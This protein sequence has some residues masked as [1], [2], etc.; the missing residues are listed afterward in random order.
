MDSNQIQQLINA[1]KAN[2]LETHKMRRSFVALRVELK[3]H[4]DVQAVK[5]TRKQF[6]QKFAA[7]TRRKLGIEF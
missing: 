2:T 4:K 6:R 1:I 5:Q 3:E 7:S